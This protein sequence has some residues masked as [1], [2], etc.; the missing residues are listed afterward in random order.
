MSAGNLCELHSRSSLAARY[1]RKSGD[2]RNNTPYVSFERPLSG[3][4]NITLAF[5]SRADADGFEVSAF[6]CLVQV[7]KATMGGAAAR[8]RPLTVG[9]PA[10]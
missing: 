5:F 2:V 3:R 9:L 8:R 7:F 4:T 1:D 6:K 10:L